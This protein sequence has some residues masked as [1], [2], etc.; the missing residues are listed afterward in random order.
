M[1]DNYIDY[2]PK[3]SVN[4]GQLTMRPKAELLIDTINVL[5]EVSKHYLFMSQTVTSFN[6]ARYYDSHITSVA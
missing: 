4:R 1:Y 6:N 3:F 2:R 5:I